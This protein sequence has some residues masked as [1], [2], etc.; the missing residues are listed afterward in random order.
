VEKK[1]QRPKKEQLVEQKIK[2]ASENPQK[3]LNDVAKTEV[4]S[5]ENNKSQQQEE[6]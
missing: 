6:Q 3:R 2:A 4:V 1:P 5:M